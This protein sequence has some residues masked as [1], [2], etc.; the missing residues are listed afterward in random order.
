MNPHQEGEF[1]MSQIDLTKDKVFSQL[2]KLDESF[3]PGSDGVNP[4]LL[5]SCADT[6]SY[7]LLLIYIKS[8]REGK[9]PL[10]WEHSLIIPLIK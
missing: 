2:N 3:A 8:L 1:E 7:P 9:L 5:K 4:K 10:A 6:L